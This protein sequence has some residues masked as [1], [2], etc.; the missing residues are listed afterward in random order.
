MTSKASGD[1][2]KHFQ[3]QLGDTI[4]GPLADEAAKLHIPLICTQGT[5]DESYHMQ[6]YRDFAEQAEKKNLHT[7]FTKDLMDMAFQMAD[8]RLSRHMRG[9]GVI[10]RQTLMKRVSVMLFV[11]GCVR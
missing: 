11:V 8:S 3:A 2:W 9:G 6:T 1:A 10:A 5:R 4:V 7:A